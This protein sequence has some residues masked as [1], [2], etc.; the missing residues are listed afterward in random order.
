MT[1]VQIDFDGGNEPF[2]CK[3]FCAKGIGCYTD[4]MAQEKL[5]QEVLLST[6]RSALYLW[7]GLVLAMTLFYVQSQTVFIHSSPVAFVAFEWTLV[8]LGF[9]TFLFGYYFFDKYVEIRKKALLQAQFKDR[10]QTLLMA[11]VYQYILFETL[12]LYGVVISVFTQT[13]G[14]ALPFV[15]CSYL[16][17]LMAF[18]RKRKLAPFFPEVA[19]SDDLLTKNVEESS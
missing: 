15:L 12:G 10:K 13:P 8:I 4:R 6:R 14:K 2:W 3:F 11:F 16:G 5:P 1:K 18:P 19:Q 7:V 17:F 9:L